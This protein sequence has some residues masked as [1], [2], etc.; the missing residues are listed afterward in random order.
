MNNLLKNTIMSIFAVMLL[1]STFILGVQNGINTVKIENS[2]DEKGSVLHKSNAENDNVKLLSGHPIIQIAEATK[3]IDNEIESEGY[4]KKIDYNKE[5]DSNPLETGSEIGSDLKPT[6]SQSGKVNEVTIKAEKLPN[7]QY[8]YQMLKHML[9]DG[10]SA[11]DLTKRYSQIPTIPGPS[12][13]MTQYDLL[14]L[15]SIDETGLKKTQ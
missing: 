12:I 2:A 10:E 7:G 6:P 5:V 1:T 13:E 8:A 3:E 9:Y 15:H 11:Q 4:T 14:I